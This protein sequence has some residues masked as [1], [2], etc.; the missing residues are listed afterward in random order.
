MKKIFY[1]SPLGHLILIASENQLVYCNWDTPD[2]IQKLKKIEKKISERERLLPEFLNQ[3][4]KVLELTILQLNEYFGGSRKSFTIPVELIGT[5]FQKTVWKAIREI[6]YSETISYKL[7][8]EATGFPGAFQAVAQA[9]GANPLAI[10]FPC[11]RV[12]AN[13]GRLGGYTGGLDKK[14]ALLNLERSFL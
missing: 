11:H 4:E 10:I 6:R 1:L 2:C 3:E 5:D 7:L 9:C 14:I 8:A 12:T 13:D